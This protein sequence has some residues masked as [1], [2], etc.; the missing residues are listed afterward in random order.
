MKIDWT[1]ILF[2]DILY[3]HLHDLLEQSNHTT[4]FKY[5]DVM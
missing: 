5:I 2:V 3:I 4:D 1:I